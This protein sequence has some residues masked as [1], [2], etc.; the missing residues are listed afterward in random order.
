MLETYGPYGS[1]DQ[2]KEMMV[3]LSVGT[4]PQVL[5]F[6]VDT[7]SQHSFISHREYENKLRQQIAKTNTPIR[8][9]GM[10]GSELYI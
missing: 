7:G 4:T 2:F 5:T 1:T 6:L 10:G 3:R 8:M 9:F